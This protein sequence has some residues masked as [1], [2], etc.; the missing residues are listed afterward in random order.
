MGR[1]VP[2]E[3][4]C[5]TI[6]CTFRRARGAT[7]IGRQ[8]TNLTPQTAGTTRRHAT[9]PTPHCGNKRSRP[10]RNGIPRLA[11]TEPPKADPT[12]R[13]LYVQ[14]EDHPCDRGGT[15]AHRGTFPLLSQRPYARSSRVRNPVRKT[16]V[17]RFRVGS[18]ARTACIVASRRARPAKDD[19]S[20]WSVSPSHSHRPCD[21]ASPATQID[22]AQTWAVACTPSP[23]EE[24][25]CDAAQTALVGA[26]EIAEPAR[27][28]T[29]NIQGS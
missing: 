29:S 13:P 22:V 8:S 21:C 26:I 20:S 14:R 11:G 4:S 28:V 2:F 19:S 3:R 15:P 24:P 6:K 18:E 10:T 5:T 25:V 16:P 17:D 7:A 12:Q 1:L 23:I 27:N 9:R